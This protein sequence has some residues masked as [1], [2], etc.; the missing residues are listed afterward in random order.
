M[1]NQKLDCHF[2]IYTA[3]I[4]V[5]MIGPQPLKVAIVAGEKLNRVKQ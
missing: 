5:A 4:T 2:I 3:N 1:K